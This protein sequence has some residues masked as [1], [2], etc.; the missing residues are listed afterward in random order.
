MAVTVS[1]KGQVV[2]PV[3]IRRELGIQAGDDVDFVKC[4]GAIYVV[5]IPKDPIAFARGMFKSGR[6]MTAELLADRAEDAA[7]DK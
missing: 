2:I 6:S 1:A 3:E 4:D 5:K 7:R